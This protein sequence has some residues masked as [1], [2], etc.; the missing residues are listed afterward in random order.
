VLTGKMPFDQAV[1]TPFPNLFFLARG[2]SM[3]NPGEQFIGPAANTFLR[4]LYDQFDYILIDTPPVLAADDTT[5][6]APKVDGVIFV[7]RAEYTSARLARQSLELLYNRH[8]RVLGLIY[9]RANLFLPEYS[10][11][12][13]ASYYQSS[14]K[15]ES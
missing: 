6:L 8:V 4:S 15:A 2:T 13:Y 5:S 14:N 10:Y 12:K 3:K 7:V 11:Y 1:Q 9:N